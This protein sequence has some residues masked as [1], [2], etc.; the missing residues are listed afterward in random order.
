MTIPPQGV[1]V[2]RIVVDDFGRA[3]SVTDIYYPNPRYFSRVVQ[4][5]WK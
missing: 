1:I 5:Y 4:H 3:V 2:W